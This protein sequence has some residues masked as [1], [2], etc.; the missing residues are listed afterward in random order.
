VVGTVVVI[1][2]YYQFGQ[3]PG[4]T[5]DEDEDEEDRRPSVLGSMALGAGLGAAGGMG[6]S[7]LSGMYT[8]GQEWQ[9]RHAPAHS[10]FDTAAAIDAQKQ[11]PAPEPATLD[12]YDAQ[13][14]QRQLP[15]STRQRMQAELPQSKG[16]VQWEHARLGRGAVIGGL[17]GGATGLLMVLLRR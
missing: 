7:G 2:P 17:A 14:L 8:G 10:R 9:H 1:S 16:D 5:F 11:A 3:V 4:L 12:D 13:T 6:A 15:P